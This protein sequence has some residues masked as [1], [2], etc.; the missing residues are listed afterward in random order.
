MH[1]WL[2]E[3][4]RLDLESYLANDDLGVGY[5]R[6]RWQADALAPLAS[7]CE[8]FLNRRLLKAL[9][10]SALQTSDRLELLAAAQ[11][12][13]EA[14]G[15]DPTLSC[16][17][18]QHQLHGYHP[19]RGGL[20]LWD[21]HRLQ[22]LEQASALVSSLATPAESAWLIHPRQI[23]DALK[24]RMRQDVADLQEG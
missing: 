7:L 20:R 15:L 12:M 21:G 11:T 5:Q 6:Q 4:E 23:S 9:D 18:R 1:R 14:A 2:W 8:R 3:T 10:V 13:S 22:A 19:Y 17:L 16:G 24:A